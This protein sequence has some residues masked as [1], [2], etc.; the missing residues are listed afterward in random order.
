MAADNVQTICMMSCMHSLEDDRIYWKQAVSLKNAGYRLIHLGVGDDELDFVSEHGIR[1][2]QVKKKKFSDIFLINF[3]LK[4]F[5]KHNEYIQLARIARHL[6]ADAYHLHDLQLN[7]IAKKIKRFTNR[8]KL[9]YDAHEPYPITIADREYGNLFEKL[10]N[11]LYGK[12]IHFWEIKSSRLYD[13]I[14][15]TEENVANKFQKHARNKKRS[16]EIIYNYCNWSAS[17][18]PDQDKAIYDFIYTGGIRRRRGAME[19]L[20]AMAALKRENIRAR[21]LIVGR[22]EDKGLEEE[23][24]Q[25][26]EKENISDRVELRPPVNYREIM[27]LYKVSRFGMAL[28]N[29]QKVNQ[30]ILPIKILEYIAFGL[31][32]L[33]CKTGHIGR[34]TKR[35]NTGITADPKNIGEV[36]SAMKQMLFDK[37]LHDKQKKNCREL[38][39]T[40]FNWQKM[41]KKL[42]TIYAD[43]FAQKIKQ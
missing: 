31:P 26:I 9:I 11:T 25:F 15:A 16:V 22:V 3:I 17:D 19:M 5:S 13:I 33:A 24:R 43:L 42:N 1:L 6:E 37:E 12:Y 18:L 20:K 41:E 4:Q 7:K 35:F 40:D 8:P 29:N 30:T 38:Y 27:K 10:F 28:F 2:I 14:I 32:V 21:M 36:V 34:I 39:R 23:M